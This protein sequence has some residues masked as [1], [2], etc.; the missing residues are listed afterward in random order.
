MAGNTVT[1]TF[2]G[3]S[4]SLERTFDNV[5]SGAKKMAGDLDKAG[6]EAK[7]F[8]SS[9]D[10]VNDTVDKSE[11]KFMGAADLL[12]GLGGAFGLPLEG[13]TNMAR[14]FAD[15]AG[16]FASVL[17]P[18]IKGILTKIGVLTTATTA[19][20]VATEGAAAAQTSL[21]LDRKSVV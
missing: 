18:A 8:G 3:D 19:E 16:G 7:R 1:L 14:S 5:G 4:K 21:N 20:A 13:A 9:M 15:L 12:D 17:G 6:G 2:A 10:T 11:G